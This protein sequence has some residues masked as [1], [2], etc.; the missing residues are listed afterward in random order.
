MLRLR[1]L[2]PLSRLAAY[3]RAPLPPSSS[4]LIHI[5]PFP[6]TAA[7]LT[8]STAAFG[9][10]V[11]LR[12][13]GWWSAAPAAPAAAASAANAAVSSSPASV[14][15]APA[16]AASPASALA[17]AAADSATQFASAAVATTTP[18]NV[19]TMASGVGWPTDWLEALL[20][21][22]HSTTGLP[23]W[24]TIACATLIFRSIMFP[25]VVKQM[26]NIG[27]VRHT[28]SSLQ[29]SVLTSL[30]RWQS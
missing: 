3:P 20:N 5:H 9:S 26:K 7:Q 27:Q 2:Q 22:L 1:C 24:A 12:R 6:V 17:E 28:C 29:G 11:H 21:S 25:L 18:V 4:H 10:G 8:H 30:R 19:A 13:F 23:W 16:A 15:A 14:A